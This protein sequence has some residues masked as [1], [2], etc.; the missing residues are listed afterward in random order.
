MH[1]FYKPDDGWAGD[2]I[3]FWSEG[4]YHLFYL[5][6]VRSAE[7]RRTPW[8]H[9]VSR[10]FV[11]FNDFGEALPRG[12][13][14]DFDQSVA[15]GSVIRAEGTFHAFYTGHNTEFRSQGKP[16]AAIMHATS[17]DL[18]RW[19]KDPTNPILLPDLKRYDALNWR[20]PFVFWNADENAYWML[21]TARLKGGFAE[22]GCIALAVS[23]DLQT[24]T[25]K[26]PFWSPN[27]Y[28]GLECP[29]LFRIGDWWYLVFSEFSDLRCTHYRVSRSLRG[30]WLAPALDTLDGR[31]YYAAKTASDGERRY[32]FG[33]SR[34]R[35][36]DV[37]SG[38]WLWG[39]QLVVHELRQDEDG[40]LCAR[41]PKSVWE[42]VPAVT[43]GHIEPQL[44]TWQVEGGSLTGRVE[45]G[46]GWCRLGSMPSTSRVDLEI[47]FAP[48]T[49]AC[50]LLLRAERDLS[51][52]YEVRVEPQRQRVVFDRR[53]RAGD[54][55]TPGVFRSFGDGFMVERPVTMAEER[56]RLQVIAD[57][58]VIVVYINERVAL[59][60]AAY[61]TAASGWG[62]FVTDGRAIFR[63]PHT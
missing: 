55:I 21:F 3:P 58:T 9:V 54:E 37:D 4:E 6:D 17:D 57:G 30:P 27:L 23:R 62:V 34:R 12:G 13:P 14:D 19:T 49:R 33:W 2:F 40:L 16:F 61:S 1:V 45:S 60:T 36:G 26:D 47:E 35:S 32:L 22:T 24:W 25:L 11:S 59:T 42:S 31:G 5:K 51:S 56:V 7:K 41:A 38:A 28:Y 63:S 8:F 46:F 53:P 44:G 52:A 43:W 48:G 39:G 29:D 50:G 20:D 18:V 15:T 10:D